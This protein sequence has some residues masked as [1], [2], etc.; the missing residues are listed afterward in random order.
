MK[1]NF[2]VADV[3][4]LIPQ[5]KKDC[6]YSSIDES[7]F[8]R[9]FVDMAHDKGYG[10]KQIIEAFYSALVV[11]INKTADPRRSGYTNLIGAFL[12]LMSKMTIKE[13][14]EISMLI[15]RLVE[16]NDVDIDV[17]LQY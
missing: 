11:K 4:Q 14:N 1:K 3:K 10:K 5:G 16:E 15:L 2:K 8:L 7:G 13:C 9:K 12:I 6:H 17:D